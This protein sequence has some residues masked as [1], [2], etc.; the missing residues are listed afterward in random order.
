M[1]NGLMNDVDAAWNTG[2]L[3]M[4]CTDDMGG[5][6]MGGCIPWCGCD[7]GGGWM[8]GCIS[9]CGCDMGGGWMGG[10]IPWCGCGCRCRPSVLMNDVDEPC[11]TD[12]IGAGRLPVVL[13]VNAVVA[14]VVNCVAGCGG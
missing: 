10:C 4:F 6:W 9:W 14:V 13:V 2:G 11:I 5:G 7:M 3:G 8:G 12:G 1:P